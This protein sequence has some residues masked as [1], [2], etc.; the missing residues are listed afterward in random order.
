MT[1]KEKERLWDKYNKDHDQESRNKIIVEYIP[2][3]KV[4]ASKMQPY[5][6]GYIDYEEL[7][8][9]GTFGLIDAIDKY[10]ADK[11]VKFETYASLRIRGSILDEIRKLDWIPREIRAKQNKVNQARKSLQK[12]GI[13]NPTDL[14]IANE[15]GITEDE[16]YS[17]QVSFIPTLM[18]RIDEPISSDTDAPKSDF[19]EQTIFDLPE[20]KAI[21]DLIREKLYDAIC[22]LSERDQKLIFLYYFENVTM[23]EIAN[24]L[25]VSEGRTSQLHTRALARMKEFLKEDAGILFI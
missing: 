5:F 2:L 15:I 18:E 24:I 3:V 23:K 8:S 21:K 20:D 17:W 1:E 9:Y 10:N 13:Q 19:L 12:K 11:D 16:Y 25:G 4:V 6:S 14:E 7:V 22:S